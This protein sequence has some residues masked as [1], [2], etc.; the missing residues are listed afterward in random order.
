MSINSS[1]TNFGIRLRKDLGE[2]LYDFIKQQGG[3]RNALLNDAIAQYLEG[4]LN[5]KPSEVA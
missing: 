1:Q 3:N 4:Q 2:K 5:K